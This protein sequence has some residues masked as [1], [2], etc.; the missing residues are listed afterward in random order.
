MTDFGR[1]VWGPARDPIIGRYNYYNLNDADNNVGGMFV[2]PR[3]GS[4]THVG[5]FLYSKTGTPPNYYVGLVTVTP[6]TGFLTTT[7]YGTSVPATVDPAALTEGWQWSALATPATAVA[8]DQI[9]VRVWPTGSPGNPDGSNYIVVAYAHF[10]TVQNVPNGCYSVTLAADNAWADR[11]P[12]FAI[13][14]A[15]GVVVGYPFGS[16]FADYDSA[17]TPDERGVRFTLPYPMRCIGARVNM[18]NI[19]SNAGYV[20]K[21]YDES[22]TLLASWTVTDEDQLHDYGIAELYWSAPV[23]LAASPSYYRLTCVPTS[24]SLQIRPASIVWP[25]PATKTAYHESAAFIA[26]SRTDEGE[27]TDDADASVFLGLIVDDITLPSAG[28]G[29]A[30]WV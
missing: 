5:W 4:I 18:A 7:P 14:Y 9:G 17:D 16:A 12:A 6:S 23:D 13:K 3:S 30:R 2:L 27:W 1:L 19:D 28:G 21:L 11:L 10:K 24:S 15:D 22:D 20:V 25:D 8:G 26:T 29:G